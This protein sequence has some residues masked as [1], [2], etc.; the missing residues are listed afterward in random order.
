MTPK[1]TTSG[2]TLSSVLFVSQKMMRLLRQLPA[3]M[4]AA[5][6]LVL[7]LV[8]SSASTICSSRMILKTLRFSRRYVV[9]FTRPDSNPHDDKDA[10]MSEID[11]K[12][13]LL[14]YSI[15]SFLRG[16][17][18]RPFQDDAAAPLPGLSPQETVQLAL[19]A[20]RQIDDPETAHGAACFLRF[21]V[22]LR[23][24]ERWGISTEPTSMDAAWKE[25]L[26]GSLTPTMFAQR[27]RAS[28]DLSSL[29][30]WDSMGVMNT[31]ILE[32]SVAF[33][34]VELQDASESPTTNKSTI[35]L[36]LKLRRVAGVWLIESMQQDE[37]R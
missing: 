12:D 7:G 25:L 33:C 4:L 34:T 19:R 10:Q 2:G 8:L 20:L 16:D 11:L 14:E 32:E 36:Q 31:E 13:A 9:L 3:V 37:F 15:D 26:R 29:L 1:T 18:D 23:R 5:C 24:G 6:S 17:Y 22:P 35:S 21:C 28:K 27:L 30:E